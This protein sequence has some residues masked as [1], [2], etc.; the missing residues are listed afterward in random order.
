MSEPWLSIVGIGEDGLEGL[1]AAARTLL[2]RAEVII[3]GERHLALLPD[4]GRERLTW[5]S[6][7]HDLVAEIGRRRGQ[8]VCV[9]ATGDPM[10]YGIGVTLAREL[11]AEDMVV[12]PAPSA[13]A[14]ACARLGWSR[15]E[16]DTLTLHG[17]PLA[18]LFA[19]LTPGARLLIL[20]EDG[21][22]PAAIA[23]ALTERGYGPSPMV[24]LEHMGGPQENQIDG[25][26]AA[27]GDRRVADFNTLAVDC[28]AEGGAMAWSSLAGLD[29]DAFEHDGQLTK[30]E[31][32]A[33]TLAALAPLPGEMLW[34]VGAGS[35]AVAIEWLRADRRNRAI[36]IERQEARLARIEQ[37]AHALGVPQLRIVAGAAPAALA[38]LAAP[39]AI[40]IGGGIT[41]DG[42]LD[43]CW[44]ALPSGGRLVA[45]VV[46]LAGE[47]LLLRERARLGG[48]LRRI[49][50][51]REE[52][53]G[54]Q[55]GWRAMRRVTQL[56]AV[57]P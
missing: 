4:D 11:P 7:L 22:A 35:G 21:A 43:A 27:W 31:V 50:I 23:R 5:P 45:N 26:A 56:Q 15:A 52:P 33:I 48:R 28:R 38:D 24:V 39:D 34:D 6:P 19:H 32:R 25:M 40:F 53:W 16:V 30:R 51:E 9:L 49:A 8:R 37:N 55:G 29:D 13:F 14:L 10:H 57:K 36:A 46:T 2:E 3:G 12:I 18:G 1:S 42:L 17:R 44:R 41:K 47:E 54:G 20:T